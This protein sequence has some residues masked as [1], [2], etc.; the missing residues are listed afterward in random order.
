MGSSF[1]HRLSELVLVKFR[2][3]RRGARVGVEDSDMIA[4]LLRVRMHGNG[5]YLKDMSTIKGFLV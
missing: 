4:C 1:L 2:F 3:V 5:K